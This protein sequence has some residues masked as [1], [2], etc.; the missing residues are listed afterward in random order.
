MD[1]VVAGPDGTTDDTAV[2]STIEEDASLLGL[3]RVLLHPRTLPHVALLGGLGVSLHLLA[4]GGSETLS[5]IGYLS[6][7]G[8]YAITA[9]LSPLGPVQRWT[10]LGGQQ[11]HGAALKRFIMSFRIC[12]FPLIMAGLTAFLLLLLLGENGLVGDQ[13]KALP[14][15]L[16]TCFV[17]WAVLQGRGFTRWLKTALFSEIAEDGERPRGRTRRSSS[18][19]F[20]LLLFAVSV[21]LVGFQTLA[22]TTSDGTG[23]LVSNAGFIAVFAGVF[24]LAWRRTHAERLAASSSARLHGFTVRWMLVSQAFVSWHLLTVWR[25]W[26]IAPKQSMLLFEELVLMMFTVV[27]A[28]WALTSKSFK[29]SFQLVSRENA[30]PLGLAFGYAYAGSVAMMTVVLVDVRNVVMVGHLIVAL[31]VLWLQPKVLN[32][33]LAHAEASSNVRRIVSEVVVNAPS[34]DERVQD[35]ASFSN[36]VGSNDKPKANEAP[37]ASNGG[38][39]EPASIGTDVAWDGPEVLADNVAWDDEVEV[40]D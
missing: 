2:P 28:I 29:S 32:E 23:A 6:L 1:E 37:S 4:G 10:T 3:L 9:L 20:L 5:S 31:T 18:L 38:D 19:I 24:F 14:L 27:M 26:A 7:A 16:A 25:H 21:L 13:T 33:T 40:V 22:G 15:A 36:D 17:L 11:A 30:L 39:E 35:D 8:G 12:I 34:D